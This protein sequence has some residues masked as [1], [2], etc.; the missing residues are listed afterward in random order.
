MRKTRPEV[1]PTARLNVSD[2]AR[3]LKISRT[4]VYRY[5]KLGM[6]KPK[7]NEYFGRFAFTGQSII[8]FWTKF[9]K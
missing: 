8:D 2:T 3:L 7:A 6:L 4:S 5:M 9:Y 1:P